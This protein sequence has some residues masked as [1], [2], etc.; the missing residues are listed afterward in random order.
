[1]SARS[2]AEANQFDYAAVHDMEE[3]EAALPAFVQADQQANPQFME[4]FTLPG[5][6]IRLL[7]SYYNGLK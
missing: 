4:V 6:D 3:L 1:M 2:W 5:E 7:N